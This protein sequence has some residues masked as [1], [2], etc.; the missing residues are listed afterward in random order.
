MSGTP[1][2]MRGL[3]RQLA[4]SVPP[5]N[6]EK[7]YRQNK[8]QQDDDGGYQQ[9]FK[10]ASLKGGYGPGVPVPFEGEKG[11]LFSDATDCPGAF[12]AKGYAAMP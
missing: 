2:G 9:H 7:N 8:N 5:H 1:R 12:W 10:L 4:L 3:G 11:C 6:R